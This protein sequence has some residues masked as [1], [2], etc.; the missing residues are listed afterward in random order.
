MML[1]DL[2]HKI[3][4]GCMEGNTGIWVD[5]IKMCFKGTS[6][7]FSLNSFTVT[8]GESSDFYNLNGFPKKMFE[9]VC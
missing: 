7:H 4:K 2:E 6:L 5:N 8:V 3:L 1:R 9:L